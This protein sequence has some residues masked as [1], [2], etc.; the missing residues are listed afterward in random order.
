MKLSKHD[1]DYNVGDAIVIDC[2]SF[3]VPVPDVAWHGLSTDA[4]QNSYQIMA[5]GKSTLVIKSALLEDT[6][7]YW[8]HATNAFNGN[9]NTHKTYVDVRG[10]SL[11]VEM[12][13][14]S[15]CV[16]AV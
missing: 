9:S 3:G 13:S 4:R 1:N 7:R 2:S 16:Y 14:E 11:R 15:I 8:C 12:P 5:P 10:E 6:S